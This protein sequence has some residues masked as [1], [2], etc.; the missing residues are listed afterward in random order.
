MMNLL[1][2]SGGRAGVGRK[3]SARPCSHEGAK[4]GNGFADDQIL[5]LIRAF[6]RVQR[7]GVGEEARGIVVGDDTVAAQ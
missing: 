5:H 1:F 3:T 7:L 6:V 4:P 2:K